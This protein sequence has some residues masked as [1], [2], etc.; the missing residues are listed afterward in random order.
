MSLPPLLTV[1]E[2][3]AALR[4]DPA[5]VYRAAQRGD[6]NAVRLIRSIH[7]GTTQPAMRLVP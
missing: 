2:V 5:T 7:R 3:A 6:I 4:L 1:K